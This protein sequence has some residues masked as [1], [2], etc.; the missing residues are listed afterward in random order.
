MS[1][2]SDGSVSCSSDFLWVV[3]ERAYHNLAHIEDCL[4]RFDECLK[5]VQDAVAV[6]LA[7]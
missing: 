2:G 6:E 7:I 5:L 3:W 1:K 4:G